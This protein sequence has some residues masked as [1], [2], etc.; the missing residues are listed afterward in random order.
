MTFADLVTG[1]ALF[2]DANTLVYHFTHD[3]QFGQACSDLLTRIEQGDLQGLT[4]SHVVAE[5]AHRLMT[6]EASSQFVWP[7]AGI[8]AR[9]GRHPAQVQQLSLYRRAIDELSLIRLAIL[10]VT[11]P[12]VSLAADLIRQPGLLVNDAVIVV[13]MR[14]HN[15]TALASHDAD[16]DRVP[17]L[18]R[19]APA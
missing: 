14:D 19:Y 10:P 1:M 3:P 8:A 2:L 4:S 16:F 5:M 11:G 18:T 7:A 17:G 13:V 6:H 15:L 12:Q 9:M